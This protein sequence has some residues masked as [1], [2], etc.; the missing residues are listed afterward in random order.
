[1]ACAQ[2][3]L[4]M[5]HLNCHCVFSIRFF[6]IQEENLLMLFKGQMFKYLSRYF[7]Y[8]MHFAES[9]QAPS[10]SDMKKVSVL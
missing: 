2:S 5:V 6:F 9:L 10:F 3:Y 8:N 4:L 1:M 7:C